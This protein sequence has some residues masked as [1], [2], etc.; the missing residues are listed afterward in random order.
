MRE[1]I[2]LSLPV[3]TRER[4]IAVQR[5]GACHDIPEA[6]FYLRLLAIGFA[7]YERTILPLEQEAGLGASEGAGKVLQGPWAPAQRHA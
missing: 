3:E 4:Y 5:A 1:K 2:T 6:S 7:K